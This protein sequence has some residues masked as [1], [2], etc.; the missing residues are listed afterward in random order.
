MK[1]Q[2]TLPVKRARTGLSQFSWPIKFSQWELST[3]GTEHPMEQIQ[4]T[5]QKRLFLGQENTQSWHKEEGRV[6]P[7]HLDGRAVQALAEFLG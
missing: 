1:Q 5:Q 6:F 7:C 2:A 4:L 3:A